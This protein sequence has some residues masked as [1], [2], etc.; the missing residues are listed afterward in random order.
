MHSLPLFH[1]ISGKRVVVVGVGDMA[2]AK[3]RLVERAGGI[4]CAETE[5]HHAQLAFVALEDK[6]TAESAARR[7]KQ[8]GLL[9][10]VADRPDLCD[11]TLPSVLDRDPVLV[12]VSTGGASAGLAKHLRLR[13]ETLL[14]Q[15][16]GNLARALSDARDTM[17]RK[18]PDGATRRRAL[19]DALVAEGPLDPLET[20]GD[21]AVDEWLNES[22]NPTAS[23]CHDFVLGSDDPDD[24]T[25]RQARLLGKADAVLH[26][27]AISEAI[28]VR[29]RA[30]AQRIAL[31]A[32]P[33]R[34]GLSV[35]L[36]KN[37]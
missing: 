8:A 7:L 25:L 36:R 3:A 31:P 6:R 32:K 16:L 10:N 30:D 26:D 34:E 37:A 12:A 5:A 24:L 19:D 23:E 4:P 15:S 21:G 27:A 2:D 1:R 18:F 29:A 35:I 33:P 11:F 13:L 9:V 17:R 28:L 20:H 22:P 14:P